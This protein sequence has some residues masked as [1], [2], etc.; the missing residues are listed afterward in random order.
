MKKYNFTK[1][2]K[3]EYD[4]ICKEELDYVTDIHY[5]PDF[6]EIHGNM[7]GDDLV[8]RVYKNGIVTER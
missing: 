8:F 5:A 1:E 6:V 7:G 4:S 2:Q 3:E